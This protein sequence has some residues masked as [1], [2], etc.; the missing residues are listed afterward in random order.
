MRGL[1][2]VSMD[3]KMKGNIAI[4]MGIVIGL[5]DIYWTYT[6]YQDPLWLY[7]G[8]IIFIADLIWLWIDISF[9]KK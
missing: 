2:G 7:L 8:I 1:A 6:S 9:K 3:A 4:L 5:A